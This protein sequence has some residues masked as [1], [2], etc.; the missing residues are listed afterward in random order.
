MPVAQFEYAIPHDAVIEEAKLVRQNTPITHPALAITPGHVDP[1]WEVVERRKPRSKL[2]QLPDGRYTFMT[3]LHVRHYWED[4]QFKETILQFDENNC[5]HTAPYNVEVFT[6]KVGYSYTDKT[7]NHVEVELAEV[8]GKTPNYSKMKLR[9]KDNCFWWDDVDTDFDCYLM[10][11]YQSVEMFKRLRTW[12]APRKIKWS[13]KK[14]KGTTGKFTQFTR[15][16]DDNKRFLEMK[17]TYTKGKSNQHYHEELFEEEWTGRVG[18]ITRRETRLKKWTE[19]ARHPVIIDAEFPVVDAGSYDDVSVS[20][21]TVLNKAVAPS[22]DF[23]ALG[24][25]G[26]QTY[27]VGWRFPSVAVDNGA[28]ITTA[29]VVVNVLNISAGGCVGQCQMEQNVASAGAVFGTANLPHNINAP[30]SFSSKDFNATGA[31][32]LSCKTAV[33]N[34]VNQG[35]WATSHNMRVWCDEQ[36]KTNGHLAYFE[37]ISNSGTSE[38]KLVVTFSTGTTIEVPLGPVW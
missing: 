27:D 17:H 13:H 38:A 8:N 23:N 33:Q 19:R 34:N 11:K 9:Q 15:G 7:G 20:D 35:G 12:R 10:L 29:N 21:N 24:Q 2:F 25:S 22:F 31:V 37:D 36:D 4:E 5:C 26:G 14:F 30:L 16:K 28:T 1:E 32:S 3:G 18:K 6:D